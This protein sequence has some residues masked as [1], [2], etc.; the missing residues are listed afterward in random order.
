VTAFVITTRRARSHSAAAVLAEQVRATHIA[1]LR[2][3]AAR[4]RE[5]GDTDAV[6]RYTLSLLD[7]DCYD[8]EA[9]LTLIG[10]LFDARRLGEARRHYQSYV[11]RMKEIGFPPRPLSQIASRGRGPAHL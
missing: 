7:Q 9:H 3:L 11:R 5:T 2:A 4:L 1:V 6:V 10:V 8:E